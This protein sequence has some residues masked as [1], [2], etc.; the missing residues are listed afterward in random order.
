MSTDGIVD[1]ARYGTIRGDSPRAALRD[2]DNLSIAVP[3]NS[4]PDLGGV[5]VGRRT[6]WL[7][8]AGVVVL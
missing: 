8:V 2:F 5:S 3:Q 6:G 7:Y 1:K 4:P